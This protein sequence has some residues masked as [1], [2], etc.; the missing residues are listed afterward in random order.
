MDIEK[1]YNAAALIGTPVHLLKSVQSR[2]VGDVKSSW[3]YIMTYNSEREKRPVLTNN[4]NHS[5]GECPLC[6]VQRDYPGAKLIDERFFVYGLYPNKFPLGEGHSLA[7]HYAHNKDGK[8][9]DIICAE[10]ISALQEMA[11]KENL[12]IGRNHPKAGMSIAA[13]EHSHVFPRHFFK[14][15]DGNFDYGP[16]RGY[17]SSEFGLPFFRI[18]GPPFSDLAVSDQRAPELAAQIQEQ[19]SEQGVVYTLF[20]D[21]EFVSISPRILPD[22]E[23]KKIGSGFSMGVGFV[24]KTQAEF[25]QATELGLEEK[26]SSAIPLRENFD[27]RPFL[28]KLCF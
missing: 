24:A 1:W 9:S 10:E 2:V 22:S 17:E 8:Y 27:W 5:A 18:K 3:F 19:F 20:A 15:S 21:A 4:G 12:T 6:N 16:L 14:T 23:T 28:D 13:H 25:E 11:R 7:L 26:I